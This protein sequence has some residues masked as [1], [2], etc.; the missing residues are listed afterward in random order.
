MIE[1]SG[2]DTTSGQLSRQ[3]LLK[4]SIQ[5]LIQQPSLWLIGQQKT[6]LLE[7]GLY[8]LATTTM[9]TGLGPEPRSETGMTT[10]AQRHLNL[11]HPTP[12]PI[13]L[14]TEV[15]YQTQGSRHHQ[16][17]RGERSTNSGVRRITTSPEDISTRPARRHLD[18]SRVVVTRV[19]PISS[20][21]RSW[22]SLK[23]S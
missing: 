12:N 23:G 17:L 18:S 7:E 6:A 3:A 15:T 9:Q 19:A 10:I 20:P 14:N 13:S 4:T 11:A 8:L 21:K 16:K 22:V 2:T 1:R 5:Q